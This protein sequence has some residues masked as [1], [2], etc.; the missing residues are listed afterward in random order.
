MPVYNADGSLNM[1]GIE[2]FV[3]VC[4]MIRDHSELIELGVTNLG[5]IDVFIGLDWLQFH[6]PS[7]DWD[8]STLTFNRCPKQCG[9]ILTYDL[10]DAE[11]EHV[12]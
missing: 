12:E 5:A 7:I 11:D 4:M 8:Q 3:S 1:D 10:P 2:G 6:N 9:Y